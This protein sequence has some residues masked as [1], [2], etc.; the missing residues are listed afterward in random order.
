MNTLELK[1]PPAIVFGFTALL[2]WW[3]EDLSPGLFVSKEFGRI[4][5]LIL[6]GSGAL[7]GA[8]ALFSFYRAR[9]S[10][11]PHK[12]EKAKMLVTSGVYRITRNP[13][14]LG[15]ALFL[16]GWAIRLGSLLSL[17][18]GLFFFVIYISRFQ[19]L[20]EERVMSKKFG[21]KYDEYKSSVRMWI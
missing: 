9:T 3:L 5:T 16:A 14:Y 8:A 20:P 18:I 19:I 21:S 12:P 17:M 15:M 7:F 1:I 13:M 2:M 10:I 6:F 4:L 11:D